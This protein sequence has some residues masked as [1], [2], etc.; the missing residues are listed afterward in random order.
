MVKL[1]MLVAEDDATHAA[2]MEM[3]LDEMGYDAVGFFDNAR[4][5][6][7]GLKELDP[8]VVL[9]DI[10]LGKNEDGVD[11]ARQIQQIRPTPFIFVTSFDDK[12]T[13]DRAL[14]TGPNAYLLKPVERGNLQA[15]IEL[16]VT[17]FE[18][19][20]RE[21]ASP[22]NSTTWNTDVLIRDS[23]FLKKGSKLE[24]V[25]VSDILWIELADERYCEVITATGQYHLRISLKAMEQ[26]LNHQMFLRIHRAYIVNL[27]RISSIDDT[28]LLITLEGRE[29]PFGRS[30]K[31]ELFKRLQMLL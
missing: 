12:T 26:Q 6:L 24:K 16:A 10:A 18:Q 22:Q 14:A 8:D 31:T 5:L 27:S 17:K 9:L 20:N 29:I 7:K 13:L 23:F 19:S 11:I 30:Y 1:R 28:D 15:A 21:I 25:Q 3:L 2:K 4:D